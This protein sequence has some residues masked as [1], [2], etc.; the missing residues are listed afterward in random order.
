M[1]EIRP[2]SWHAVSSSTA[3]VVWAKNVM[4]KKFDASFFNLFSR[5]ITRYGGEISFRD[6]F[7]KTP[8]DYVREGCGADRD[9]IRMMEQAYDLE[10]K[11]RANVRKIG[12][13][14]ISYH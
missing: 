14:E 7:G 13:H 4:R 6:K 12:V 2:I 5:Y 9:I 1:N 10:K 3:T 8:L 11:E